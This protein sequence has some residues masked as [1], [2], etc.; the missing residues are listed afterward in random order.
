MKK[1]LLGLAVGLWASA[2]LVG[3]GFA[4]QKP[5]GEAAAVFTATPMKSSY[6]EGEA[7]LLVLGLKNTGRQPLLIDGAFAL[8][9]SI[10]V[11]ITG[12]AGKTIDWAGS[13]H[14][15]TPRFQSLAPGDS[16]TRVVCLNC[17]SQ[18]PF[19]YPLAQPGTYAV[20]MVY[21]PPALTPAQR[22]AFQNVATLDSPAPAAPVEL[23]VTPP[24]VQFTAHP[25]RPSF[26]AGEPVTFVFRLQNGGS[27]DLL[28][29]YD[30]PF[31]DAVRL[32]VVDAKGKEVPW[33]GQEASTAPLLSTI[34]PG[35]DA[36]ASYPIT[37]QN[38]FG[39]IIRG[40][41][42]LQPGAYTAYAVYDLDQPL[43]L[44]GAYTTMTPALIVPGPLAAPP[45]SFTILP[46]G[47][48]SP[49]AGQ[50]PS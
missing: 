45:V 13:F 26:A 16:L 35:S 19:T 15:G 48:P 28:A 30:L 36:E 9:R 14:E 1:I 4:A 17:G 6:S 12:P 25:T 49:S 41:D 40:V 31:L 11:T 8:G 32:R 7:M 34:G 27:Q 44:L 2:W 39:T 3:Q 33:R 24:L 29:A 43:G 20:R 37:P 38:I 18:D 50:G 47:A 46:A 23:N 42:L 5:S 21:A 10:V 22:S